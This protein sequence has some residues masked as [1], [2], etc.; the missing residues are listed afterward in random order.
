VATPPGLI[1][2]AFAP[3]RSSVPVDRSMLRRAGWLV[4]R[5]GLRLVASL[6]VVGVGAWAV[7]R[8]GPGALAAVLVGTLIAWLPAT[9]V[10]GRVTFWPSAREPWLA[11]RDPQALADADLRA[12]MRSE[13]AEWLLTS[14]PAIGLAVWFV[15]GV[16]DFALETRIGLVIVLVGMYVAR[17][18]RV[19]VRELVYE[20]QLDLDAFLPIRARG[21][22]E[23]LARI[24][25]IAL[26]DSLW[27]LVA[28]ARFRDGDARGALDALDRIGARRGW[29][30]DVLRALFGVAE[31]GPDEAELVADRIAD[32][33]DLGPVAGSLRA[34]ALLSRDQDDQVDEEAL[35]SAAS[36]EARWFGAILV[37]AAEARTRPDRARERLASLPWPFERILDQTRGW[38]S[39]HQRLASLRS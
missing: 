33:P 6:V 36:P 9:A 32:D 28:R 3:P 24:P 17:Q 11:A 7:F 30:I 38:P 26:R 13:V 23:V 2:R 39:V 31:L 4:L 34:L 8:L 29:R 5:R 35:L 1:D 22:V 15:W 27:H 10:Q 14:L 20:G 18:G 16:R 37:A 21:A 12:L 25:G 19:V